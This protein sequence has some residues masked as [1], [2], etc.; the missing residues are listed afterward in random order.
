VKGGATGEVSAVSPLGHTQTSKNL[1]LLRARPLYI[2]CLRQTGNP[3]MLWWFIGL[4]LAS[5]ALVPVFWLLG[6]SHQTLVGN[7]EVASPPTRQSGLAPG[8]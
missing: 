4:W 2:R 6:R 5:P 8:D 1:V 7:P 3:A